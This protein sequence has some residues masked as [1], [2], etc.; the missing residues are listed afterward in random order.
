[1][2]RELSTKRPFA[3]ERDQ[4]QSDSPIRRAL[5]RFLRHRLAVAGSIVLLIVAL[6]AIAAPIVGRYDPTELDLR[7][8]EQGPSTEHWLGTDRT[9]RD[10]W[11]RTIHA[12]RVS[13]SVGLVAV[14]ISTILGTT[15]GV[16]S[17]YYGGLVDS[18]IMRF[19]DVVMTFPAILIILVLVAIVGPSLL[20]TM[21][22]IGFLNWPRAA[23]IVRSV[24]LSARE[25]QYVEAARCIGASNSRIIL[26]HILPNAVAPLTVFVSFGV[27]AA[28]LLEAGL[29]FL[30]LG[31][32]P[33]TPSW[34]NMLNAA[35]SV[36]VMES[37]P[38]LWLSPGFMIVICVLAINFVGDGLRDALDPRSTL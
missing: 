13:L 24:V 12:G 31:V 4:I 32:Q 20:N 33:P 10:V 27:A 34:G 3:E 17:G 36:T 29:S 22:I 1:M 14:S 9:G 28:I 37:M 7:A 30:G 21:L 19:T 25:E 23:R 26:S 6:T 38:W 8:R 15:L 11:S 16:L 35:R 18:I 2:E 5:R